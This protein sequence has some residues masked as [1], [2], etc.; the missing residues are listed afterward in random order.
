MPE[1][2]SPLI[3]EAPLVRRPIKGLWALVIMAVFFALALISV[4]AIQISQEP[5]NSRRPNEIWAITGFVLVFFGLPALGLAWSLLRC[6]LVV[7]GRGLTFTRFFS[8]QFVPWPAVEDYELRAQSNQANPTYPSGYIRVGGKW[9]CLG[10][11]Y[12]QAESY[13]ALLVRVEAQAKWSQARSWQLQEVRED[14]EWPKSFEYQDSSGWKLVALAVLSPLL[15]CGLI[16]MSAWS[17]AAQTGRSPDAYRFA[18]IV[19]QLF[20]Y[21]ALMAFSQYPAILTRRRY[22]GQK[23]VVTLQGISLWRDGH[24]TA[25][26]WDEVESYYL[27]SMPG[28]LQPSRAVVEGQGRRIEFVTGTSWTRTLKLIVQNRAHHAKTAKWAY[29]HGADEN[30]L[31]GAA[32][33]WPGGN[34]GVGTKSHH[35]RT[36]TMRALLAGGTFVS[37]LIGMGLI[38]LILGRAAQPTTADWVGTT[39]MFLLVAIPTVAMLWA[40]LFVTVQ[41]EEGG[42]RQMGVGRQRFIPWEQVMRLESNLH[43]HL[44]GGQQ[45]RIYIGSLIADLTGLADEIEQR[46]GLKWERK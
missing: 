29:L 20:S 25:L 28:V 19:F 23:I 42:L 17:S 30:V 5:V 2:T 16:G 44:V 31:G 4:V 35:Y 40:Y 14:G 33:L 43:W 21:S 27:E 11:N 32:S 8:T 45:G 6:R 24:E 1:N 37:C 26:L 38:N 41:S 15:L 34:A 10:R 46:T 9:H 18:A 7:D 22:L 13:D 39:I 12:G 36:R 3:E